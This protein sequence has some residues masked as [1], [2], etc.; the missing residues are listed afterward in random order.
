MAAAGRDELREITTALGVQRIAVRRSARRTRTISARREGDRILV[1]APSRR[2]GEE[3]RLIRRVVERVL[4]RERNGRGAGP[5]LGQ[6]GA[7][8]L[9]DRAERLIGEHFPGLEP[10]ASITW[11]TNQSTRWGSASVRARTIRLS[12][13]LAGMPEWVVDSVIVHELAHLIEPSHSARFWALCRRYPR[14]DEARAYL[15]GVEHGMRLREPGGQ[16][17]SEP[18]PS[19]GES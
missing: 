7:S 18:R 1:L 14:T 10:P 4:V 19:S 5:D 8:A 3:E 12:H 11:V 16:P 15:A 9:A 13:V 17:S 2:S 6:A